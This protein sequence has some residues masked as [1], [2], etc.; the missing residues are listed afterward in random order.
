MGN[1]ED[2]GLAAGGGERGKGQGA[3]SRELAKHLEI[4]C[5]EG[6][7]V[8]V[9]RNLKPL[10]DWSPLRVRHRARLPQPTSAGT[11][12]QAT[13]LRASLCGWHE[14]SHSSWVMRLGLFCSLSKQGSVITAQ[15]LRLMD[16]SP[17]SVL[18]LTCVTLDKCLTSLSLSFPNLQKGILIPTSWI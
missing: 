10:L 16:L 11:P 13:C 2:R 18:P 6:C 5:C 3:G 14:E 8:P 17:G 7:G 12:S 1:P 15:T 4:A 9:L